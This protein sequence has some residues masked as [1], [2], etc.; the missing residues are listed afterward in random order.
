MLVYKNIV[1]IM[2]HVFVIKHLITFSFDDSVSGNWM[3][4]ERATGK[5]LDFHIINVFKPVIARPVAVA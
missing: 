2:K 4:C 5:K 3:K 1:I